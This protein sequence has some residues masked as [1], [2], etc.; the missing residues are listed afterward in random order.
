MG[1]NFIQ[2]LNSLD[3]RAKVATAKPAPEGAGGSETSETLELE[4][5]T[6]GDEKT[7]AE[8]AAAF[9]E[10]VDTRVQKIASL[11]REERDE[12]HEALFRNCVSSCFHYKM[13]GY[14]PPESDDPAMFMVMAYNMYKDIVG[15]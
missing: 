12:R 8:K 4:Q 11:L 9:V 5:P 6:S 10:H 7:A 15:R 14:A 1:F 13:A 3:E 2:H